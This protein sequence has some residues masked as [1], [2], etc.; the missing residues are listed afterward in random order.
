MTRAKRPTKTEA[1]APTIEWTERALA[2]LREID[3][4]IAADSPAAAERWIARLIAKA[5]A[6]A[7]A[8]L[9]GPRV[10][11]R[12]SASVR[13][14]FLKTYRI[15]YRVRERGILVL[16]VFEGHRELPSDVEVEGEK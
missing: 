3:E 6:A 15:V 12:A 4:Y 5:E 9:A 7:H 11:E 16:T 10:P 2:D 13:E 14:V 1:A 8:P